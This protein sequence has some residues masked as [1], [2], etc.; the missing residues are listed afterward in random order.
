VQGIDFVTGFNT[1]PDAVLIVRAMKELN[2]N[3]LMYGGVAGAIT[4][5]EFGNL[6]G[7]DSNYLI[8][9]TPYA[10]LNFPRSKE[11]AA[12][13]NKQ[14]GL[15]TNPGVLGGFGVLPI[16][17]AALE[18]NP[19]HDRESFKQA[20]DKVE[21]KIGEFDFSTTRCDRAMGMREL[22]GWDLH[23]LRPP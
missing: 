12:R 21:L 14:Y 10:D 2:Y 20:V 1:P 22:F 3:P 13:Y 8:A 16:M 6:L 17:R 23:V 19:T 15:I 18:K 5:S 11:I 4:M 9:S 7:K